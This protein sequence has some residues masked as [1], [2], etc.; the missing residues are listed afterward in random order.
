M[1]SK[2]ILIKQKK[3]EK[4]NQPKGKK[5]SPTK[6]CMWVGEQVLCGNGESREKN[7]L[8]KRERN[9]KARETVPS[10]GNFYPVGQATQESFIFFP[11]K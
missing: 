4:K 9:T 10:G 6:I 5:R 8:F 2:T 3:K 11:A 7:A 1:K